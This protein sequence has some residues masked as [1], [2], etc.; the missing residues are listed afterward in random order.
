MGP[1]EPVIGPESPKSMLRKECLEALGHHTI[2]IQD[3]VNALQKVGKALDKLNLSAAEEIGG[4]TSN[5]YNIANALQVLP[6]LL[7]V[8]LAN[9]RQQKKEILEKEQATYSIFA[10]CTAIALKASGMTLTEQ[11]KN[12]D[13]LSLSLQTLPDKFNKI[14]GKQDDVLDLVQC[15]NSHVSEINARKGEEESR[16]AARRWR[17]QKEVEINAAF[18]DIIATAINRLGVPHQGYGV[19]G[20]RP[21]FDDPNV[22]WKQLV[23]P[24]A[25]INLPTDRQPSP[26]DIKQWNKT[27]LMRYFVKLIMESTIFDRCKTL[28]EAANEFTARLEK[29]NLPLQLD[30]RSKHRKGNRV[31]TLKTAFFHRT[32]RTK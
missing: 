16:E 24:P 28:L 26:E 2:F 22:S 18:D 20:S 4:V 7:K 19:S 32:S 23:R 21:E 29:G 13:D 15:I 6:Q 31:P 30:M 11:D 3:A 8:A 27:Q 5:L 25:V 17:M 9:I 14:K 12:L 1:E 10:A